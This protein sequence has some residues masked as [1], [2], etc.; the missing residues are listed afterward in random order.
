MKKQTKTKRKTSSR[1]LS[2][3]AALVKRLKTIATEYSEK[4]KLKLSINMPGSMAELNQ[5]I[6]SGT[7]EDHLTLSDGTP[8]SKMLEH[9]RAMEAARSG[10]TEK[11][12]T[13]IRARA[14][15]FMQGDQE[16]RWWNDMHEYHFFERCIFEISSRNAITEMQ[17]KRERHVQVGKN[18]HRQKSKNANGQTVDDFRERF[19]EAYNKSKVLKRDGT[20]SL[21]YVADKVAR[22][23]GFTIGQIRMAAVRGH[24]IG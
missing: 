10:P 3:A 6:R 16:A 15:A 20:K 22:A 1:R 4:H 19:I 23:S 21:L 5:W 9:E 12:K 17:V 8:L 11:R 13:E 24:W 7:V 18:H 2:M 14:Q